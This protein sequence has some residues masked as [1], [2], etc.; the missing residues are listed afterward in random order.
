V[1]RLDLGRAAREVA[2]QLGVRRQLL[3]AS[4]T[5]RRRHRTRNVSQRTGGILVSAVRSSRLPIWRGRTGLLAIFRVRSAARAGLAQHEELVPVFAEGRCPRCSRRRD[6]HAC[7]VDALATLVPVMAAAIPPRDPEADHGRDGFDR[8]AR[9]AAR[10]SART[11][12][13]RGL[14]ERRSEREADEAEAEAAGPLNAVITEPPQPVL[15]L[16]GTL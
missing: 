14:F 3:R 4:E 7:A 16:F 2:E 11:A 8:D 12:V 1:H 13:Q 10:A 5:R 6:V 15:L 9:I